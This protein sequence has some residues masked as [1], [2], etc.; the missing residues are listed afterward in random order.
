MTKTIRPTR[1][2][3]KG[4]VNAKKGKDKIHNS[5]PPPLSEETIRKLAALPPVEYDQLRKDEAKRLGIRVSVLDD[6]VRRERKARKPAPAV[7]P[8][9]PD[10]VIAASRL[11]HDHDIL[12]RVADV[13]A[14][15]GLVGE[16]AALKLIYLIMI[17]R[18]LNRPVSAKVEGPSSGGT[19]ELVRRGLKF[20]PPSAYYRLTGMSEKVLVYSDEPLQHRVLVMAEA[21]GITNSEFAAY[22]MRELLS[23]GRI[24]YEFVQSTQAGPQP[25]KITR[26]GPISL[27]VTTT[28]L[29]LDPQLETRI[30][31]ISIDDTAEQTR[32]V[33]LKIAEDT[34]GADYRVWHALQ[35]LLEA[36]ERRVFI[37][38]AKPIAKLT[39][40]AGVRIRRDFGTVLSL[41]RAHALLHQM[42]REKDDDGRIVATFRDYEI[43]R[44]LVDALI[45]GGVGL[46]IPKT[47]RDTV[48]VVKG[49][50]IE[51]TV[52]KVAAILELDPSATWR[53]V[54]KAI[55][56]GYLQNLEER[57]R[58]PARLI[59][60]DPMPEDT[61][62][63]PSA[64][65]L[66][67]TQPP[68]QTVVQTLVR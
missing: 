3:G 44:G 35:H 11:L 5:T 48:N 22:L 9:D 65:R 19:S 61:G 58:Q 42:N 40:P 54:R 16:Q 66:L 55:K 28:E 34:G 41:I 8:E 17:S 4:A 67:Q 62:V 68:V 38:F 24:D 33:L 51:L 63:L 46:T 57:P 23:E 32:K 6:L 64:K 47:V 49:A 45:S 21:A 20:F 26:E 56:L 52:K 59:P 1:G 10:L 27:L 43:V 39:V 60:G 25:M 50:G 53:R 37:P 30:L 36:G 18:L 13:A 15:D 14:S 2:S 31:S 12:G 29:Q 7:E